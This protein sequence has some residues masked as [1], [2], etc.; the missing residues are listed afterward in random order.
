M[1]K[2]SKQSKAKKRISAEREW[3]RE[4]EAMLQRLD[5]SKD[6]GNYGFAA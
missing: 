3:E 1:A 2:D 6:Y 5:R 4:K